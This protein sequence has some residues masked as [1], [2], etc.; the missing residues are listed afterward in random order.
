MAVEAV[1]SFGYLGVAFLIALSTLHL[2]VPS[3]LVLALAGFLV[4]EG[5]FSFVPL[6]AASTAGALTA[7]LTLYL[8]GF[9]AGEG[10]VRR[11]VGR[12]GR[13][14]LVDESD[15][16]KASA[17]FER[18]GGKAI[19]IG[20]LVPGIGGFISIPAGLKRMPI[21]GRYLLYT[22]L[23]SVIWNVTFIVL[24]WV[25]GAQ[26]RLVEKYAPIAEYGVLGVAAGALFWFLWHRRLSSLMPQE[27]SKTE[28]ITEVFADRLKELHPD[29]GREELY[30]EI[31]WRVWEAVEANN[32]AEEREALEEAGLEP[33]SGHPGK[34][35]TDLVIETF[36]D[37]VKELHLALD[38]DAFRSTISGYVHE[39]VH[40]AEAER[41]GER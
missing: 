5:R 25:F 33:V 23:G 4:D 37:K 28:I 29:I 12:Y 1:Y 6:L 26:W 39:A 18:H 13:F 34:S 2:P 22:V 35:Y 17:M 32:A 30:E 7:S 3:Q 16:D 20:H 8:P 14:V 19:L 31:T 10:L 41:R 21:Y 11:L 24:G 9:W 36:V 40:I 27:K 15:L 38:R